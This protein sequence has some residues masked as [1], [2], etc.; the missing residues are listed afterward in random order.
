MDTFC[1]SSLHSGV[2]IHY[3]G[4]HEWA[5]MSQHFRPWHRL[6]YLL[7]PPGN[8]SPLLIP[9][10]ILLLIWECGWISTGSLCWSY[11]V[12]AILITFLNY[13]PMFIQQILSNSQM[14][15][16]VLDTMTSKTCIV[17]MRLTSRLSSNLSAVSMNYALINT[18]GSIICLYFLFL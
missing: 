2:H 15:G 14:L 5:S 17:Y 3:L 9:H 8:P 6:C 7:D 11:T 12:R 1:R 10:C 4:F 18:E 16:T 13:P